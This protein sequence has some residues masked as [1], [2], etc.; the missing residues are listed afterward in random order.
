[1][2]MAAVNTNEIGGID[3]KVERINEVKGTR[4]GQKDS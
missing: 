3:T 1:M 4:H 2:A